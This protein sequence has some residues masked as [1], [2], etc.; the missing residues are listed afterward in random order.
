VTTSSF[1]TN[2][3]RVYEADS[4]DGVIV[5]PSVALD[6]TGNATVVFPVQTSTGFQVQASRTSPTD[7]AWPAVPTALETDNTAKDNDPN[8]TLGYV[9]MPQVKTDPAGN[10]TCVWRKRTASSGTRFD[11]VARRYSGG[12]WGAQAALETNTT[13]SVF[14]PVLAVGTN[15]TAVATWYF[16]NTLDVWANVFK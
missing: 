13:N 3:L 16:A 7:P 15:G 5:P 11:L 4:I 1:A 6:D 9:T 14:W 10:V 12:T 8:S 2:P